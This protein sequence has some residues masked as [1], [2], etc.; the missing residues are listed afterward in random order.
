MNWKGDD[1]LIFQ[2]LDSRLFWGQIISA[3]FQGVLIIYA[4]IDLFRNFSYKYL[5][6]Y[7]FFVICLSFSIVDSLLLAF[8]FNTN[9]DVIIN[10]SIRDNHFLPFCLLLLLLGSLLLGIFILI[11][12]RNHKYGY[13]KNTYSTNKSLEFKTGLKKILLANM[14]L[15]FTL[16]YWGGHFIEAI[17]NLLSS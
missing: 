13:V 7:L 11:H 14:I 10:Y 5:I 12:F 15:H 2:I 6:A 16:Y 1:I 3:S 4:G 8:L 17:F 9:F